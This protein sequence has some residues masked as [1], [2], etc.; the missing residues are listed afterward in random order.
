MVLTVWDGNGVVS[1][2]N[3]GVLAIAIGCMMILFSGLK[4]ASL[5]LGRSSSG[6]SNWDGGMLY[7][8]IPLHCT[9]E[10]VW[11]ALLGLDGTLAW[12]CSIAD[13]SPSVVFLHSLVTSRITL[14][15]ICW[16]TKMYYIKLNMC[17]IT[18]VCVPLCYLVHPT[19][20]LIDRL[21]DHDQL[22]VGLNSRHRSKLE[23]EI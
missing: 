17:I 9:S 11:F 18:D 6:N 7:S 5:R 21:T 15:R 20:D 3:S 12:G 19:C 22:H 1:M 14:F 10:W 2:A 23:W 16:N 8:G 4:C 13:L